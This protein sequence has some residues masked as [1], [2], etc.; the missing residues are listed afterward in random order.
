MVCEPVEGSQTS[1]VIPSKEGIVM[2][3]IFEHLLNIESVAVG[4]IAPNKWFINE[5]G[6]L[7]K[8][9]DSPVTNGYCQYVD[10]RGNV[11]SVSTATRMH[12]VTDAMS[13]QLNG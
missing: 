12:P 4:D 10:F 1:N 11:F 3:T 6:S 7:C 13:D 5:A 2:P 9:I 8:L